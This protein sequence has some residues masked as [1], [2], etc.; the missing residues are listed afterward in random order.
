MAGIGVD[1]MPNAVRRGLVSDG[2]LQVA[3][4]DDLGSHGARKPH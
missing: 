3:H 1:T 4:A 2:P